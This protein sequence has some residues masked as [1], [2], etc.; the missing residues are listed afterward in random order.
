MAAEVLKPFFAKDAAPSVN[1][2]SPSTE[3]QGSGD[4][5]RDAINQML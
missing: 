5:L 1:T 2:G 4:P 3:K